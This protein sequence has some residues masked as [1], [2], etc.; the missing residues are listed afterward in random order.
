MRSVF[1]FALSAPDTLKVAFDYGYGAASS[2]AP[3]AAWP[4]ASATRELPSKGSLPREA[5]EVWQKL[6]W[7]REAGGRYASG[8]RSVAVAP[9]QVV[10]PHVDW[11]PEVAHNVTMWWGGVQ[12]ISP[13][14]N[15]TTWSEFNEN[16]TENVTVDVTVDVAVDGTVRIEPGAE[17]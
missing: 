13:K 12:V 16:V 2:A 3:T 6:L 15:P 8:G 5:W 11:V 9:Q 4:P 17:F 14:P 7:R 1:D 10:A